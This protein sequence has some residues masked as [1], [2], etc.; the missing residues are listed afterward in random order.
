ML[1]IGLLAETIRKPGSIVPRP[2]PTRSST[3]SGDLPRAIVE[4]C[5]PVKTMTVWPSRGRLRT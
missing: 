2:M 4:V 5:E 3:F 1:L